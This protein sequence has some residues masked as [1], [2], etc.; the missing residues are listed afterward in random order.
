MNFDELDKMGVDFSLTTG[1]EPRRGVS[2]DDVMD[3]YSLAREKGAKL[4]D[5]QRQYPDHADALAE[6]E[7]FLTIGEQMPDQ[8]MSAEEEIKLIERATSVVNEVLEE[9]RFQEYVKG[10]KANLN[11]RLK[12]MES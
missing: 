6:Y 8:V 11:R 10:V 4:A 1:Q 5:W 3:W 9:A 7:A 12:E 2:L